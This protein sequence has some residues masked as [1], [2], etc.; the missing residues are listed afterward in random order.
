MSVSE[1]AE[2]INMKAH[3]EQQIQA[4]REQIS[5]K[6]RAMI[7]RS[8]KHQQLAKSVWYENIF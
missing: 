4:L 7:A 3:M 8:N 5:L 1:R 6:E 2:L